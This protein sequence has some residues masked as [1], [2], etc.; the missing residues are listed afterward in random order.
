VVKART[1]KSG[2]RGEARR[3][4]RRRVQ[5]EEE[6]EKEEELAEE[7]DRVVKRVVKYRL[8][9]LARRQRVKRAKQQLAARASWQVRL[10]VYEALSC[11]CM[12]P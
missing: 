6:E 9:R 8:R 3:R 11:E 7:E 10:V 2:G 12:R 4:R 5:E 1:Q